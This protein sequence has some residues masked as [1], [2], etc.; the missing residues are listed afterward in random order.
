MAGSDG[1]DDKRDSA[2]STG[3][4]MAMICER[5]WIILSED[6][7]HAILGGRDDPSEAEIEAAGAGLQAQGLGGWFAVMTGFYH[8]PHHKI[9]L[10]M[11]RPVA[12][13]PVAWEQA[14]EAF[15]EIRRE[16]NVS[17]GGSSSRKTD[18]TPYSGGVIIRRRRRSRPPVTPYKPKASV[19]GLP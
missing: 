15:Q 13:C 17:G 2:G 5:W 14:V 18:D 4:R 16:R 9:I 19:A 3:W 10:R 11:V 6:G 1:G 7:R 12:P 8:R